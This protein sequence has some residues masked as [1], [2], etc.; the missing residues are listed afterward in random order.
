MGL[1]MCLSQA[2]S[3]HAGNLLCFGVLSRL[4]SWLGSLAAALEA[5]LIQPNCRARSILP[6]ICLGTLGAGWVTQQGMVPVAKPG[7]GGKRA[8]SPWEAEPTGLLF[9]PTTQLCTKAGQMLI[10]MSPLHVTSQ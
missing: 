2:L 5:M 1:R 8:E 4:D 3:G 6:P 10:P 9:V 7:T